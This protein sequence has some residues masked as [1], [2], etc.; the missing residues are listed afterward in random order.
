MPKATAA[1]PS[2]PSL[3]LASNDSQMPA[4]LTPVSSR[5]NENVGSNVAIPRIKL[6]QKM[7]DQV[8]KHHGAFIPGAEPGMF[9]NSLTNELYTDGVYV[10]SLMF[11]TEFV[12][13]RDM[14]KGGGYGGAYP[15]L[16]EANAQIALQDV[17]ADY[18]VSET[19]SHIIVLKDPE[20][21]ALE[22]TP[23]IMDF[24]SS[25]LRVSKG[26]NSMIGL[27]G[28]DRF[29]GMWK[30]GSVATE[31]KAGKVFHNT[32]VKWVGWALKED[33]EAAEALYNNFTA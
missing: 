21:G 25:K 28:G 9:F 26:W 20:T 19:H 32:D 2:V 22:A 18:D 17:P 16:S 11:N 15:T 13:W 6:L 5:G 27:K 12:V 29:A 4:H 33:Y 31:S 1:T 8:D 3:A 7:N 24:A 14:D 23:C 10:L 30:I